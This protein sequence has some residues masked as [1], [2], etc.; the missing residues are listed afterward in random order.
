MGDGDHDVHVVTP[1]LCVVRTCH[2]HK[3]EN[4]HEIYNLTGDDGQ[5]LTTIDISDDPMVGNADDDDQDQ[6]HG[7]P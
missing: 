5:Q 1:Q 3:D 7:D 2:C 6:D 4:Y